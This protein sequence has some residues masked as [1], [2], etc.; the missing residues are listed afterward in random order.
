MGKAEK[1]QATKNAAAAAPALLVNEQGEAEAQR[2][3]EEARVNAETEAREKEEREKAEAEA[4]RQREAEARR[5][6]AEEEE[7]MRL[8]AE[9]ESRRRTEEEAQRKAEEEAR[10]LEQQRPRRVEVIVDNLGPNLL[11]K[12]TVTDDP[13]VVALLDRPGGWKLVREV[14][15]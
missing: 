6:L 4:R 1:D 8:R 10:L 5:K 14:K 13:R 9:E 3:A 2:L 7:A 11:K 12:G 15:E